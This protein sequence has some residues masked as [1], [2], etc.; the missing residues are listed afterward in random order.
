MS[1]PEG[2]V[3]QKAP[4]AVRIGGVAVVLALAG[5]LLMWGLDL[6]Q[7][8]IGASR[9]PAPTVTI[10]HEPAPAASAAASAPAATP[11]VA[12]VP[13]APAPAPATP[14]EAASGE[15]GQLAADLALLESILPPVKPGAGLVI[16][17]MQARMATP[18]QVHYTVLLGYGPK[19]GQAAFEGQ[20]SLV[21][22]GS[23]D[24]K[25]VQ[26]RFPTDEGA[27]RY[28]LSVEDYQRVD[29]TLDLPEG[30]TAA[31][32]EVSL[33]REGKVLATQSTSIK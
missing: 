10:E 31:A 21:L 23:K 20:L 7:R 5:G 11:A 8:L 33:S 18:R 6:G 22:S 26:L 3:E 28:R 29:G 16:R 17:G 9:A 14:A 13:A 2:V 12:S 19:K 27:E 24:G 32:L 15:S 25:P 30:L 4:L 1:R